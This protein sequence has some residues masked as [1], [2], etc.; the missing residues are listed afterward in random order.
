M[1]SFFSI[2]IHNLLTMHRRQ[3][4]V[5]SY[6]EIERSSGPIVALA[7]FGTFIYFLEATLYPLLV[8]S[9]NID[10]F[11]A[12]TLQTSPSSVLALQILGSALTASGYFVFIWSVI[13]RGRY[14]VSW[15]MSENHKLVTN[16]PYRFVRHPSYLGYFLMF[17]GLPLIWPNPFTLIS[18]IAIPGYVRVAVHEERLLTE[19]FGKGYAEYQKRTGRFFPKLH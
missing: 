15:E 13:T 2:N 18:L 7:G 1:G 10:T 19:R 16:G 8:F 9:G 3:S 14:A 4:E 5:K 6:A 12:V 11:A 17:I